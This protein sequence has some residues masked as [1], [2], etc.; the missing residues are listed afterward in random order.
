MTAPRFPL[1]LSKTVYSLLEIMLHVLGDKGVNSLTI[2]QELTVA[3]GR[4]I[5]VSSAAQRLK[6][7]VDNGLVEEVYVAVCRADGDDMSTFRVS[8]LGRQRYDH[9]F[10]AMPELGRQYAAFEARKAD[11]LARKSA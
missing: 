7:A 9:D 11:R 3:T 2:S 4:P 5:S 8:R 1:T 10:H 6:L